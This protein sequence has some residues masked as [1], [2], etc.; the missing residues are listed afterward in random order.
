MTQCSS[1]IPVILS[2]PCKLATSNLLSAGIFLEA[3]AHSAQG[4]PG[5]KAKE[6][7]PHSTFT[8]GES[9]GKYGSCLTYCWDN[10]KA[11]SL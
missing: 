2:S 4:R 9:V 8:D 6:F 10:S 3:G 11:C 7:M 1:H 5:P